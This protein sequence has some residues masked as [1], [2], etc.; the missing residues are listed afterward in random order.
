MLYFDT[1]ISRGSF[2]VRTLIMTS[3][4]VK[5]TCVCVV[6]SD[7]MRL[8]KLCPQQST[9]TYFTSKAYIKIILK[10]HARSYYWVGFIIGHTFIYGHTLLY[11]LRK[12]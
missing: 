1:S 4:W 3:Y 8:R 2:C 5:M 11:F 6:K 7:W 12:K 9:R 10:N